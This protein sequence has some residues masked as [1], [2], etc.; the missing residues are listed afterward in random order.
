MNINGNGYSDLKNNYG[1]AD[2][3]QVEINS[4][5]YFVILRT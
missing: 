3:A 4:F 1:S 2:I 5:Q